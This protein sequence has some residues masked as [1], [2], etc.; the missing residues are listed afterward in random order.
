MR[1]I[2]WNIKRGREKRGWCKGCEVQIEDFNR[3]GC[4]CSKHLC[5]GEDFSSA[6]C[7]LKRMQLSKVCAYCAHL[8]FPLQQSCLF[9]AHAMEDKQF[10]NLKLAI[11]I[12]QWSKAICQ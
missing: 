9:S 11:Y 5:A 1:L 6:I 4:L 12:L 7:K 8:R 2:N 3:Q 10:C